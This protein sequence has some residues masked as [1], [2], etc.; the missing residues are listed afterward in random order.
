MYPTDINDINESTHSLYSI[1][2]TGTASNYHKLFHS[3]Y[4]IKDNVKK[5][6]YRTCKEMKNHYQLFII[7][8][9][10][11]DIEIGKK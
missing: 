3:D 7:Q 11:T 10:P 5:S 2:V 9:K 8:E 6:V 1:Y 4:P